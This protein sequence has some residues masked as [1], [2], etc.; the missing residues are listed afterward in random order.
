MRTRNANR[1]AARFEQAWARTPKR[2][3]VIKLLIAAAVVLAVSTVRLWPS[4]F[5][6]NSHGTAAVNASRLHTVIVIGAN[7]AMTTDLVRSRQCRPWRICQNGKDGIDV[8]KLRSGAI[9]AGPMTAVVETDE[10]C[11]P[12]TYGNS[13]CTNKL[14]LANGQVIAVQ[15]DHNM[16]IYPCLSPG[17]TIEVEPEPSTRS[18]GAAP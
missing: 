2:G 3:L 11:A 13:H 6:V 18:N 10:D 9:P 1:L 16:Q 7:A 14:R 8:V 4:W 12:D 15:H 5:G 17:Q